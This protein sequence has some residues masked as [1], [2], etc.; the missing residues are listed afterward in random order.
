MYFGGYNPDMKT[1]A[2]IKDGVVT[3]AKN[4]TDAARAQATVQM[5]NS[6]VEMRHANFQ[7]GH[8]MPENNKYSISNLTQAD[9]PTNFHMTA[10][11]VL[12]NTS[13]KGAQIVSQGM[14]GRGLPN[15]TGVQHLTTNQSYIKWIQPS[16]LN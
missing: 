10:K 2:M 3:G 11:G 9:R 1:T 16:P 8:N 7:L 5:K 14:I 13:N 15:N 6:I 12:S 4:D